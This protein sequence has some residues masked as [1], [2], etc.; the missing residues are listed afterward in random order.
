MGAGEIAKVQGSDLAENASK[1][2]NL[3]HSTAN[4]FVFV[5]LYYNLYSIFSIFY[6]TI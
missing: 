4:V 5:M 3:F 6:R 2:M 1:L